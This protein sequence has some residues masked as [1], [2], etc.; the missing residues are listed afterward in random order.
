[1]VS[2]LQE[3]LPHLW[4]GY[5]KKP[6][7]F[8][9]FNEVQQIGLEELFNKKMSGKDAYFNRPE[10]YPQKHK[11][12]P[13]T[14]DLKGTTATNDAKLMEWKSSENSRAEVIVNELKAKGLS[15]DWVGNILFIIDTS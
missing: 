2:Q 4:E 1:M 13:K 5:K 11:Y 6:I 12:R 8:T 3:D 15:L 14:H 9:E 7:S 10:D